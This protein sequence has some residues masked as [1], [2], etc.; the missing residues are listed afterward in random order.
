MTMPLYDQPGP[1]ARRRWRRLSFFFAIVMVLISAWIVMKLAAAEMLGWQQWSVL[2]NPELITLLLTGLVAT[3]KVAAVSLALSLVF[4]ALLAAG[5]LA[6]SRV[7]NGLLRLW[8]EIF[9]GLP[10]LLLIFFLYLGGPAVGIDVSTFW[11]LVI[12]LVLYN[13]AV[14][15]EIF[16][17]GVLSLPKGQ[18]EAAAAIGLSKAETFRIILMPQSI[19]RMLP[20]L[21]SQMVVLLKETS[22]G[23]VVSYTEFLREARTAVEYLGGTYSLPIYT[24]VAAVY[25]AINC[26]LSWLARRAQHMT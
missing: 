5:M 26:T 8:I 20:A 14:I 24:L 18:G 23:F 19:R 25:I 12:G 6:T 7:L 4:G 17:A 2:S 11:A 15:S 13:S 1:K 21:I 9:R 22:L 16:R 3:F 10:L